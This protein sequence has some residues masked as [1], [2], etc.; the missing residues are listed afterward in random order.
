M[1][2]PLGGLSALMLFLALLLGACSAASST[3]SGSTDDP[4]PSTSVGGA[5]G[6]PATDTDPDVLPTPSDEP[7]LQQAAPP[8]SGDD[9]S[10]STYTVEQYVS[11]IVTSADKYWTAWLV[12]GYGLQEPLVYYE[13]V[14]PGETYQTTCKIPGGGVPDPTTHDFPNAYYC[15]VDV[16]TVNGVEYKG[17][18]VLPAT[19]FQ[20]MWNGD[21]LGT[22][23]KT[24]GDFA[25]AYIIS[26][27]FGHHIADEFAVQLEA[28][29][30]PM[31]AI[32]GANNELLADCF[33][34]V[35]INYA[36]S[37]GVLTDTDYDEAIGAAEAVGDKPG[38]ISQDPHGTPEERMQAVRIGAEYGAN[39]HP[40]GHPGACI[41]T[42][43]R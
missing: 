20:K 11:Y 25:A 31:P 23:S 6:G 5:R 13:V 9:V 22:Q 15:G 18:L 42:Y 12:N 10:N 38:T 36:Y 43:W 21:I 30:K 17:V 1:R 16:R 28:A 32:T 29:G 3:S 33:A 34:G 37:D 26:H 27:E 40:A 8:Q 24:I 7:S 19:T 41:S 2:K 4:S 35:W 14:E 39:G